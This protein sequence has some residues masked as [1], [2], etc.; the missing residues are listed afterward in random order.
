MR[1]ITISVI[2]GN[3]CNKEVEHLAIKIGKIVAKMDAILVCGGLEGV[4]KAVCKGAK[5]ENGLTMGI[6]PGYDKNEANQYCDI[7]IPTGLNDARNVL[8]V[9]SGDIIVALPGEY[10]TLSEI[11]FALRF[12]K[13]VVSLGS[14][15]I[16]GVIQVKTAE[17][18]E[19]KI[20]ELMKLYLEIS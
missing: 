8:V 18:A 15:D 7:I 19:K 4:M 6:L 2:G 20:L 12:K 16:P 14:W 11:A 3:E 1:K 13:P 5:S 17:E 9:Q 10:G